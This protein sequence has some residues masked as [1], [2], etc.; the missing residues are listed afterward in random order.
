[1]RKDGHKKTGKTMGGAWVD[2]ADLARIDA[3]AK[4]QRNTRSGIVRL[5]LD[6]F[7]AALD[8]SGVPS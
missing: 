3:A 6:R 1:M 4:A 7:L 8:A 2:Q 5:A